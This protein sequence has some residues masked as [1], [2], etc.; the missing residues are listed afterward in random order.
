MTLIDLPCT[1]EVPGI[2]LPWTCAATG[3]APATKPT[4]PILH[5]LGTAVPA[6]LGPE[7]LGLPGESPEAGPALE[8]VIDLAHECPG[9]GRVS[10]REVNAG[11]LDPGVDGE[12]KRV[13]QQRPQVLGTEE[14][15]ARRRDISA[16][17]GY[18]GLRRADKGRGVAFLDPGHGPGPYQRTTKALAR[19]L[20]DCLAGATPAPA[21]PDVLAAQR[22]E[23][24][25]VRSERQHCWGRPKTKAA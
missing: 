4:H 5:T 14:F 20:Q 16:V 12:G 11:Q 21:T 2:H 10:K 18:A 6:E 24:A 1:P 22:R 7:R 9:T 17:H 19:K 23:R 8:Q 25:R 15:P 13:G 3:R